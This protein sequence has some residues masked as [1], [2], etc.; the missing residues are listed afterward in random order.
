M[1][2]HGPW[3]E[4]GWARARCLGGQWVSSRVPGKLGAQRAQLACLT[5][6]HQAL[7]CSLKAMATLTWFRQVPSTASV[8]SSSSTLPRTQENLAMY[9]S[10]LVRFSAGGRGHWEHPALLPGAPSSPT[11][12]KRQRHDRVVCLCVVCACVSAYLCIHLYVSVCE[13]PSDPHY[14]DSAHPI[15][16]RT[17]VSST[18]SPLN[19]STQGSAQVFHLPYTGGETEAQLRARLSW[20]P[21]ACA[22][23]R[24]VTEMGH[25]ILLLPLHPSFPPGMQGFPRVGFHFSGPPAPICA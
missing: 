20:G 4:Q 22:Q 11:L 7:R 6:C 14:V 8:T 10:R 5:A 25:L 19:L 13:R 18:A 1:A 17:G 23:Q 16:H 21:G 3:A 12:L 15:T 2:D 9:M 24:R